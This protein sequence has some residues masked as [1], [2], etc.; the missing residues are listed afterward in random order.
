MK[1]PISFMT[2]EKCQPAKDALRKSLS[3]TS[4]FGCTSKGNTQP[5]ATHAPTFLPWPTTT[6]IE[7]RSG[8]NVGSLMLEYPA[9]RKE[10]QTSSG[11]TTE[12]PSRNMNLCPS[13]SGDCAR[14]AGKNKSREANGRDSR[15]MSITA[16]RPTL[17]AAFFATP[18]IAASACSR[19]TRTALRPLPHISAKPIRLSPRRS[20]SP[21]FGQSQPALRAI[22]PHRPRP[23]R[24]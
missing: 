3:K 1:S 15:F 12:S 6:N 4:R 14:F 9:K 18:A 24:C 2:E 11:I 7:I 8:K 22:E 16:I 21:G 19:M 5:R 17:C 23:R 13:G 10:E 20:R